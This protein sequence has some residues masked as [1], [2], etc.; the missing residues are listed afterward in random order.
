MPA[1]EGKAPP[2]KRHT[3]IWDATNSDADF[4]QEKSGKIPLWPANSCVVML[5]PLNFRERVFTSSGGEGRGGFL[6]T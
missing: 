3:C 1:P 6:H 2:I 5:R 4:I